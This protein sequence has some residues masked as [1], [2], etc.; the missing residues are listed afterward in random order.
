MSGASAFQLL[1]RPQQQIQ[2]HEVV[3]HKGAPHGRAARKK[4]GHIPGQTRL[5]DAEI[6]RHAVPR[7]YS[8]SRVFAQVR[9]RSS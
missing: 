5:V 1:Q 9:Q 4:G 3:H 2:R 8:R 6:G 7:A